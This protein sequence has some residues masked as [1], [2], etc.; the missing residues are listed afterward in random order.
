MLQIKRKIILME[1]KLAFN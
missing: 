1:R